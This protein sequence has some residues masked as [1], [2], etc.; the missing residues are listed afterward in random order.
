MVLVECHKKVKWKKTQSSFFPTRRHQKKIGR[1]KMFAEVGGTQTE[2]WKLKRKGRD[3]KSCG[4]SRGF[5]LYPEELTI[6]GCLKMLT[7]GKISGCFW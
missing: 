1:G 4:H 5:R 6:D 3:K 7:L 2:R